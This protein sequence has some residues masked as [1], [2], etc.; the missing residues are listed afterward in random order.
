MSLKRDAV[1]TALDTFV[2]AG[3]AFL[4]RI[5][6]AKVLAPKDFGVAAMALSVVA[7][8]QVFNEFGLTAALIQKNEEDL[9]DEVVNSTFTASVIV[10]SALSILTATAVSYLA[11][12]Y[13]KE[14]VI[15]PLVATLALSLLAA[16]FSTV[17]SALL[18]R[19]RQFKMIAAVRIVATMVGIASAG[20]WLFFNQSPWVV[21][22]QTV[23]TTLLTVVGVV[24]LSRWKFRL[25]F[26]LRHMK[27]VFVFSGFVLA[28]DVT[29]SLAANAGVFIL[30]RTA[31][32]ASVGLFSLASYMTDTV[33]RSLMSILNR[34]TF[35]HYS[36]IKSDLAEVRRSY[37]STLRWNCRVIFP[38]MMCFILFGPNLTVH[39]LG[40][41]WGGMGGVV[42]WLALSVMIHAAGG[43]TSTLYKAIG[44]PGLDLAFFASTTLLLL[45]PGM[46]FG[47]I[48][49]GLTG[50]A[51]ATAVTKLISNVIRQVFLDR[52]VGSTA[53][54]VLSVT[55]TLIILQSPLVILWCIERFVLKST[56][57]IADCLFMGAGLL[58]YGVL[59]GPRAAPQLARRVRL[60]PVSFPWEIGR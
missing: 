18:Y 2:C 31:S 49:F 7:I 50:V 17:A 47:G 35:V 14:P 10:S 25:N 33:R 30:G 41:Q 60:S 20:A 32:P 39:F 22:F 21:I 57:W 5:L 12:I 6:V 23:V 46:I 38:T 42:R 9:G 26:N 11:S 52:I 44:K 4:F 29:V 36:K 27:E 16:P 56:N 59:E 45:F 15:Q 40:E 55:S 34:V 48:L 19:R 3:L 8:I 1:W 53:A 54:S 13:Y 43:T 51:V 58:I 37:I 28:N 24:S